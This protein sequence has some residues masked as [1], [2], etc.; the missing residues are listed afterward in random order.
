MRKHISRSK[1]PV[2]SKYVF[3]RE[4]GRL[5]RLE[6]G[7]LLYERYCVKIYDLDDYILRTVTP[8]DMEE[9]NLRQLIETDLVPC[10]NI[11]RAKSMWHE[12]SIS[13]CLEVKQYAMV[14]TGLFRGYGKYISIAGE[15]SILSAAFQMLVPLKY[16]ASHTIQHCDVKLNNYVN[17]C[18]E[19]REFGYYTY[20]GT[21][22]RIPYMVESIIV[23]PLLIDFGMAR[24]GTRFNIQ[25][26]FVTTVDTRPPEYFFY[27]GTEKYYTEKTEVFC[28]AMSIFQL[29]VRASNGMQDLLK[30]NVAFGFTVFV[31]LDRIRNTD[32]DEYYFYSHDNDELIVKHIWAMLLIIGEPIP[33]SYRNT[34]MGKICHQHWEHI[35]NDPSYN[36]L[37]TDG[38][39]NHWIGSDTV[40]MLK[41]SLTWDP[42]TRP[43]IGTLLSDPAFY[44][45]H[46][47]DTAEEPYIIN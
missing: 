34:A 2:P 39:F 13:Y 18:T 25:D 26:C 12:K 33:Q 21:I 14:N 3:F 41:K 4:D 38:K 11:Q 16:L 44:K 20:L 42:E 23:K 30:P 37:C 43:S 9:Y 46:C 35:V 19:T 45:F 29:L 1:R 32:P 24:E 15:G 5:K 7:K 8:V 27:D 47:D 22:Y 6:I 31:Y 28:W 10:P 40:N 17:D 36:P